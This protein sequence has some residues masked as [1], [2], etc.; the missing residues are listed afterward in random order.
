MVKDLGGI[1][2]LEGMKPSMKVYNLP[3]QSAINL[4]PFSFGHLIITEEESEDN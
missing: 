2:A 4:M 1:K 3:P